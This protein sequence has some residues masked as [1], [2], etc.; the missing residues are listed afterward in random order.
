LRGIKS[1]QILET[2]FNVKCLFDSKTV[3][4][5]NTKNIKIT[6]K[7]TKSIKVSF[8]NKTETIFESN[9]YVKNSKAVSL[10]QACK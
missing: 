5:S 6:L 3:S 10:L 4:N 2:I 7:S 9:K 1:S 8:F